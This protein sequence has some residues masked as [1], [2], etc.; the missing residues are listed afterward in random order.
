MV[1]SILL[2]RLYET[3]SIHTSVQLPFDNSH[4]SFGVS[5]AKR[6]AASR[7]VKRSKRSSRAR[8]D[9]P[10][11]ARARPNRHQSMIGVRL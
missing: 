1:S 9:E 5:I 3:S 11:A 7:M 10:M 6:F 2:C 4:S 8:L